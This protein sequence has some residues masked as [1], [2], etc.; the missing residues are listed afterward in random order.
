V[1]APNGGENVLVG[2]KVMLQWSATNNCCAIATV[3]LL[4]SRDGGATYQPIQLGAPNTGSY[5]WT[6]AAPGTNLDATPVYTAR[7]KVLAADCSA[8]SGEDASDAG[9]SIFD[10]ALPVSTADAP[11]TFALSAVWPNP[12]TGALQARI[13]VPKSA[14]IKVNVVD[15]QGRLVHELAHGVYP[16]GHCDLSWDGRTDRGELLPTGTYF[17]RYIT[18]D[19]TLVSRVVVER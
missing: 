6:V 17:V 2:S 5:S 4:L 14:S 19:K 13:T 11:K 8:N 12:T 1:T 7:L 9:F 10:V 3:D 18:P 15:L 16:P